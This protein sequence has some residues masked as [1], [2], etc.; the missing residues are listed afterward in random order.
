MP[1]IS[2]PDSMSKNISELI[3]SYRKK[4]KIGDSKPKSA[5]AAKKQAI[6][7]AYKKAGEN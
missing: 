5:D 6:A 2:G 7:I 3:H 4:G 1:L